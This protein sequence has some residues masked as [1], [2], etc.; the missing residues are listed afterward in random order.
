MKTTIR[1]TYTDNQSLES[2]LEQFRKLENQGSDIRLEAQFVP[3]L[4]TEEDEEYLNGPFSLSRVIAYVVIAFIIGLFLA[5]AI[6]Q[7]GIW[8]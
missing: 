4:I 8:S 7:T 1:K 5:T 2:D 6:G 3:R